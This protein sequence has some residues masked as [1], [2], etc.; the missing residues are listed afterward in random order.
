M[1]SLNNTKCFPQPVQRRRK[2]DHSYNSSR[3][4]LCKD[5]FPE[6]KM[7]LTA[8]VE[9]TRHFWGEVTTRLRAWARKD[10]SFTRYFPSKAGSRNLRYVLSQNIPE[11]GV[12]LHGTTK[13]VWRARPFTFFL[14]AGEGKGSGV[15]SINDLF[16]PPRFW[17]GGFSTF[18]GTFVMGRHYNVSL[19]GSFFFSSSKGDSYLMR[20][21]M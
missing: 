11:P 3:P 18:L 7:E 19:Y 20:F 2:L 21:V 12:W 1:G 4:T 10:S 13:L 5:G 9:R 17:G 14:W 8:W 16:E 6:S 15:T